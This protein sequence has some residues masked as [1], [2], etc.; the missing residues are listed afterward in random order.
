MSR[1]TTW[2]GLLAAGIVFAIGATGASATWATER[3]EAESRTYAEEWVSTWASAEQYPR[4]AFGDAVNWSLAGF[5]NHSLRQVV[6]IGRGGSELRIE[7]SNAYGT[8]PLGI[9]GATVG[10]TRSGASVTAGSLRPLRFAGMPSTTIPVGSV[11]TSDALSFE[12]DALESVTVT[13]YLKEPTGPATY[14]DGALATSYRA[15]GDQRFDPGGSDFVETSTSWYY[16][17]AVHVRGGSGGEG[18]VA[19]GDSLTDGWASSPDT[20][21]RYP[22]E[23]AEMLVSRGTPMGIANLGINGSKLRVDSPCFGERG[24]SRF[25]EQVLRQPGASTVIVSMGM[26]DIGTAGW[27]TG[28]CGQNPSVTAEEIIDAHLTITRMAAAHGLR[29]LGA[30]LSPMKGSGYYSPEREQIRDEVNAWIRSSGAYAGVVDFERA[31]ADPTDEDALNPV[32][33]SGDHLHP[34][35]AG[36]RAMA[37]AVLGVLR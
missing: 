11:A 37:A 31:L 20:N 8:R 19:F 5:D 16:L 30:T 25:R 14:H 28:I 24:L 4:T 29:V 22:D 15:A 36:R 13:V 33:D 21:N 32:F 3:T 35:D 7:L 2:G 23:L 6:R 1:R 26:N 34:N 10:R 9:A 17:T 18:I 12:T 27:P